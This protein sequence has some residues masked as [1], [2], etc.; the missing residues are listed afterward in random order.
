MNPIDDQDLGNRIAAASRDS[1]SVGDAADATRFDRVVN[2]IVEI[3]GVAIFAT[4]VGI[5]FLNAL[6][7]Y[8]LGFTFIWGDEIVLSLLPWLGM[9]GMF[10]AIRRR[11]VIKI[12]YFANLLPTPVAKLLQV[13][14]SVFASAMFAWLAIV[15]TYY[16]GFFG[17]DRLIY[18]PIEKGWFMSALVIG[19]ALAA[20]AYLIVAWQ[21]FRAGR[22]SR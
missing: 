17:N 4:I 18:L 2:L 13:L 8:A 16:V 1:D 12:D 11:A 19:P 9:T 5:V 15:S 3:G 10:L 7:R 6:G 21:D 14:A 22:A 20:L